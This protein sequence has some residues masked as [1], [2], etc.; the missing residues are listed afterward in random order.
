MRWRE[1]REAIP[2]ARGR[3]LSAVAGA[4]CL[5]FGLA[6][7]SHESPVGQSPVASGCTYSVGH[8]MV[9]VTTLGGEVGIVVGTGAGCQWTV[10]TSDAWLR[11]V[12]ATSRQGTDVF[13]INVASSAT[14]RHGTVTVSWAGGSQSITVTQ[15]CDVTQTMN[16]SPEGQDFFVDAPGCGLL[17]SPVSVDVPWISAGTTPNG[18]VFK[19]SVG[20]N[21]GPERIGH[22]TTVL[23]QLTI[24]QRAGNCVTAIAPASQAFDER[25]GS[26]TITVSAVPGCEWDAT[27]HNFSVAGPSSGS[28][29]LLTP[30]TA[31]GIGSGVVPFT[32]AANK[33]LSVYAPFFVV[34]GSLKFQITQSGC[35][36]AVSPLSFHVPAAAADYFVSV[37]VTGPVSCS[38]VDSSNDNNI[39]FIGNPEARS[40]S[41]DVRLSVR[42]NQTGQVRSAS[43]NVADQTVVVTQDP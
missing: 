42:Q 10:S 1:A 30:L 26:G 27:A 21:T 9:K 20:V 17:G 23:G 34:G 16:L 25:G 28:S 3:L 41:A 37:R 8:T 13:V 19:V 4:L 24:V 12:G 15:S 11:L 31:H 7:C 2:S 39:I 38:W 6:A 43:A 35:P 32:I 36:L 5:A 33:S 14:E 40:G 22:V 18:L 29:S